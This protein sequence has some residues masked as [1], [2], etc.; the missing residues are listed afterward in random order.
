MCATAR[1]KKVRLIPQNKNSNNRRYQ[2]KFLFEACSIYLRY[3]IISTWIFWQKQFFNYIQWN[4]IKTSEFTT[5]K[6]SKIYFFNI[7]GKQTIPKANGRKKQVELFPATLFP[8]YF[9]SGGI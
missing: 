3:P 4:I 1:S 2:V 9:I 7:A 6:R 8:G 5:S